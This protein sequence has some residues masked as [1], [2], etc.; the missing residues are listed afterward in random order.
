[1]KVVKVLAYLFLLA[2]VLLS[3]GLNAIVIAGLLEARET[4]V[5]VLDEALVALANVENEVFE[6]TFDVQET[7]PVDTEVRFQRQ[8]NVPIDMTIPID[9]E[10]HFQETIEVPVDLPLFDFTFEVP[11]DTKLPV[12]LDVPVN[13]VVPFAIDETIPVQTEVEIDLSVPV[14]IEMADTPLPSYVGDL[15]IMLLGLRSEMAAPAKPSLETLKRLWQ[16]EE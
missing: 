6:M 1:V 3:L 4:T 12:K 10:I 7:V 15:R 2:L 14:V 13:M 5:A 11:I 8:W 9:H 16:P